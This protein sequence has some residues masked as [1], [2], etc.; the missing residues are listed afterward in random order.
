MH[1]DNYRV[2]SV[3]K[4]KKCH[5]LFKNSLIPHYLDLEPS[6]YILNFNIPIVFLTKGFVFQM[7]SLL[8]SLL[9]VL[10]LMTTILIFGTILLFSA[11]RAVMLDRENSPSIL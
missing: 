5:F 7:A 11:L 3:D 4:D 8:V 1:Q 10:F 2:H 9:R 6:G